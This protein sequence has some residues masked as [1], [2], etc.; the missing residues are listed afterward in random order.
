MD[1]T[2]C[3]ILIVDDIQANVALIT[4]IIKRLNVKYETA[5]SGEEAM[6]KV[7]SFKPD[8][9]LLDL[10]MPDVS[11]WDV[12]KYIRDR[13]TMEQ[14]SVI[15]TSAITDHDNI[16]ECYDMGVNDYV[17]KPIV[18]DRLINTILIHAQKLA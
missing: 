16:T 14:M 17:A 18:P 7:D 9:V 11:G 5:S 13:Y 2:N 4:A 12:I 8:I 10:M 15:I 3:K 6:T 1:I